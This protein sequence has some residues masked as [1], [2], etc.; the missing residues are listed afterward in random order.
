MK[1]FLILLVFVIF[2][3]ALHAQSQIDPEPVIVPGKGWGKVV[4]GNT[5]QVVE[6]VISEGV[7]RRKFD[8]VYFI[9]YPMKGI[10]VSYTNKEDKVHAIYFYNRQRGYEKF[11]QAAV[12]TEK[13]IYWTSSPDDVI[14]AYGKPVE[15]HSGFGWRRIVFDGIDFR[16]EKGVMVRIGVPGK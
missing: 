16:F 13:G 9:D 7:N 4:V 2:P 5:R 6:A 8:D 15:D 11:A 3:M 12:K 14:S 10:Q 1:T